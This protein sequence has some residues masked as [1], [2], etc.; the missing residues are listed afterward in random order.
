MAYKTFAD[1]ASALDGLLFDGMPPG[2]VRRFGCDFGDLDRRRCADLG[3][4]ISSRS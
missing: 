2:S 4:D 3:G 1:A